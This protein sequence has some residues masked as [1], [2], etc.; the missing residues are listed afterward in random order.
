MNDNYLSPAVLIPIE[1]SPEILKA[2]RPGA[3]Q[4]P[5]SW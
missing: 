1:I 2:T 3:A 4:V 5:S